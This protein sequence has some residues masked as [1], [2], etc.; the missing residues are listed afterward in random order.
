LNRIAAIV[1]GSNSTRL[2][3]ADACMDLTNAVRERVETR[4]F[5]GMSTDRRL[6]KEAIAY[7][8]QAVS[9]LKGKAEAENAQ[10]LGIYAT[11]ASRDAANAQELGNL[12]FDR[13]G[14]PLTILSGEEEAGYSFLGASGG[15]RCGVIDI[16][17]GSTEVV[18]G[19]GRRL[20]HAQSLQLGAS[21]LFKSHPINCAGDVSQALMHAKNTIKSLPQA[22][23]QHENFDTF[24]LMGGTC[25]AMAALSG[26]EAEG[27]IVT[28]DNARSAL[29]RIA[30]VPR[31]KR[32]DIPGF[33]PTR[34]DILPTGLAILVSVMEQLH[35]HQ[36]TVTKRVNADGLLRAYVHKK[37]A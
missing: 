30:A 32:A 27:H 12:I 25:T 4:L 13:A 10:L 19:E 16:G 23:L 15:I 2:L 26:E 21:R 34:I 36:A 31:E 17:G 28:L 5:L 3:A 29:L 6:T 1:I 8:A 35:I 22:I 37:F 14:L 7:T 24:F 11:S 18:L 20:Y 33:P 9:D